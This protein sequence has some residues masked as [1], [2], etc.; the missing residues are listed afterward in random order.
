MHEI[1]SLTFLK[2][3]ESYVLKQDGLCTWPGPGAGKD[4][5]R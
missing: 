5:T 1:L 3:P 2:N 4:V